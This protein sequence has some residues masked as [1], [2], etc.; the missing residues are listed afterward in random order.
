MSRTATETFA[1][2]PA[3]EL[4]Q[5]APKNAPDAETAAPDV[6]PPADAHGEIERWNYPRSNVYK[7][8]FS[9]FSFIITGMN[10]GAVGVRNP[11]LHSTYCS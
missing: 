6:F 5:L 2:S 10:D 9:F 1:A 3:V 4:S 8:G 11:N 7:M